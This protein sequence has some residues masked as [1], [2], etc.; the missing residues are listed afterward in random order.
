MI[1]TLTPTAMWVKKSLQIATM[2]TLEALA[3]KVETLSNQHAALDKK[4]DANQEYV[5]VRF[6]DLER[7]KALG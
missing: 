7:E 4:V 5:E 3:K 2:S 1:F 6:L